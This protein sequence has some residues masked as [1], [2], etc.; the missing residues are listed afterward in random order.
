M[1]ERTLRRLLLAAGLAFGLATLAYGEPPQEQGNRCAVDASPP[2]RHE[3]EGRPHEGALPPGPPGMLPLLEMQ[4]PLFLHELDLSEAQQDKIFSVLLSAAPQLHEQDKAARR[5][6][7]ELHRLMSSSQYDE[8]K[9][10]ALAEAHAHAMVQVLILHA[11]SAH[12]IM[13][14]LTPEQLAKFE[15]MKA[16]HHGPGLRAQIEEMRPAMQM[17]ETPLKN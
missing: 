13:A 3:H 6:A 14:V 17:S 16:A 5:S 12:Q 7:D 2:A 4:P 11:R 9:I 8:L 15:S 10:K 1:I